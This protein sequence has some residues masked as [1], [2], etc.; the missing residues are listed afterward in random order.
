MVRRTERMR[1]DSSGNLILGTS[2]LL[3]QNAKLT[4]QTSGACP[5]QIYST[6]TNGTYMQFTG[7]GA[8]IV[9]R[10]FLGSA[11]QLIANQNETD[12]AVRSEGQL[13]FATNGAN[14]RMRIRTD[15]LAHFKGNA[16]SYSATN[17][18]AFESDSSN[19]WTAGFFHHGTGTNPYGVVIKYQNSNPG[20]TGNHFMQC[21]GQT[22]S[23]L[24]FVLMAALET[25]HQT[26]LIFAMSVKRKIS[27]HLIALGVA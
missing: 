14:E 5:L 6:S 15:G 27:R 10:A 26:M 1:L 11:A 9:N 13:L 23:V 20:S 16:S 2:S 17:Y 19:Q 25:T 8:S 4:V 12:F 24:K 3:S 22:T 18:H 21:Y 7:G